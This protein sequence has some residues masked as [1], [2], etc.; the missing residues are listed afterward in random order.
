MATL[1]T[2]TFD[3][4]VEQ[5]ATAVQAESTA[6]VDF[7]TGSIPRAFAQAFAA[8]A[9]W[10]QAL[11]LQLLTTTRAA[12]STDADLD[13]WMADY[14]ATRLDAVAA[15]GGVTFA[16]YTTGAQASIEVGSVVQTDDGSEQYTVIADTTQVA[17]SASLGAYI[18][19]ASTSSITATVQAVTA[20]SAGNASAGAINTMSQAIAG[21]DTVTNPAAFDNGADAES[22]ASFYARFPAYLASL[23]K[24]TKAAIGYAITSLQ[25]GLT[26]VITEC[27]TYAGA[28]QPGYF[29]VVV[30]DGS[31]A[32]PSGTLTS[33]MAA[34]DA[35]RACGIQFAVFAPSEVVA[36]VA[37][38][39]VV[40]AGYSAPAVCVAV[41]TAISDYI[42]GLSMGQ[43]LI[44]TKLVAVIYGVGGVDSFTGLLIN[45]A[46]SDIAATGQQ[47]I[48]PGT[49]S[50][51]S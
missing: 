24:A 3:D 42:S 4:L 12:T 7:S 9:M 33:V 14:G 19:P 29:Y 38:A 13:S 23:F 27:Q 25:Q 47:V 43:S 2:K 50:A 41:Q 40:T 35:E 17:Y 51:T 36:N 37:V 8:I 21:V 18:I 16:R 1:E 28:N 15:S 45:G 26:Y 20:G 44:W 30:D 10:L 32:P 6:L 5:Q 46:A 49:V 22:D 39:L 11:I 48:V 34:V 31:G